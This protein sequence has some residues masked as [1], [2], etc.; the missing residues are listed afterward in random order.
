MKSVAFEYFARELDILMQLIE[1]D[2]T[3]Y[4]NGLKMLTHKIFLEIRT[5]LDMQAIY[6]RLDC[7]YFPALDGVQRAIEICGNDFRGAGPT[8]IHGVGKVDPQLIIRDIES[9]ILALDVA[10]MNDD[11]T[12]ATAKAIELDLEPKL[13]QLLQCYSAQNMDNTSLRR[14]VQKSLNSCDRINLRSIWRCIHRELGQRV[15]SQRQ[16]VAKLFGTFPDLRTARVRIARYMTSPRPERVQYLRENFESA[17]FNSPPGLAIILSSRNRL[18]SGKPSLDEQLFTASLLRL[19]PPVMSLFGL[20]P[21]EIGGML[22]V[23]SL[24]K[25]LPIYQRHFPDDAV[26]PLARQTTVVLHDLLWSADKLIHPSTPHRATSDSRKVAIYRRRKGGGL[27]ARK[28]YKQKSSKSSVLQQRVQH[29]DSKPAKNPIQ[30]GGAGHARR[31]LQLDLT[32]PRKRSNFEVR[33][34]IP[35]IRVHVTGN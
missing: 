28:H 32:F 31:K 23:K 8:M 15:D 29:G 24:Q 20:P 18:A 14:Y 5:A 1:T 33:V 30:T 34:N 27:A 16:A 22:G 7:F 9:Q 21:G 35:G 13:Q 12:V 6:H 26:T 2:K 10:R 25:F 19:L 17:S 3:A 11:S 4:R